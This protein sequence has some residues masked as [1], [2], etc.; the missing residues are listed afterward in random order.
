MVKPNGLL[1][2]V[3]STHYYAY[4]SGLSTWSSSTALQK[5][6]APWEISS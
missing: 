2:P 4:T 5:G 1:V 3:S 6:F